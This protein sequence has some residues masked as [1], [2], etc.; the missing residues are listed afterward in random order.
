MVCVVCFWFILYLRAIPYRIENQTSPDFRFPEVGISSKATFRT[1][2]SQHGTTC[3]L[4]VVNIGNT[5]L[6]SES[7]DNCVISTFT[8]LF[9][10]QQVLTS[11]TVMMSGVL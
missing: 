11:R 8:V 4:S 6:K 1:V 9:T 7:V 2:Y 5:L 10:G 3:N